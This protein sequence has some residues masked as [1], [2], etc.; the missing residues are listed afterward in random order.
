MFACRNMFDEVM[1]SMEHLHKF[2]ISEAPK[3]A[4]GERIQQD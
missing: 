3:S 2:K 4:A 1:A